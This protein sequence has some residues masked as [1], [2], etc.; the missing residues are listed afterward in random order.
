MTI[1]VRQKKLALFLVVAMLFS[2]IP[3]GAFA[4]VSPKGADK[5]VTFAIG[6]SSY[7]KGGAVVST[8][9]APYIK[10]N[11]T[12]VPVAFVAPALGTEKAVWI[13]ESQMVRITRG[14]DLIMI[15]IGSRELVV[16]GKV[17]M[18]DTAAE[19]KD[20]GGGGG[21]TMLP[22]SFIARALGVGY[23]WKTRP[24][25]LISTVLRNLCKCGNLWSRSWQ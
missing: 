22:I 20:I 3:F 14:D 17:M 1:L 4:A 8:D 2:M 19:I 16:N 9:V 15:K 6:E 23:Q 21:R 24:E 10:D 18:M 13:P 11:R 12:M 7:Q 5:I 25:V